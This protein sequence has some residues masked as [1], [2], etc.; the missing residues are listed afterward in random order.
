MAATPE[1]GEQA[2]ESAAHRH[3]L[4]CSFEA[5][6]NDN[7]HT[8]VEDLVARGYSRSLLLKQAAAIP[9]DAA[10]RREKLNKLAQRTFDIGTAKVVDKVHLI[11]LPYSHSTRLLNFRRVVRRHVSNF[12]LSDAAV[13]LGLDTW[14]T[15]V[16]YKA[17]PNMF[18]ENYGLNAPVDVGG[19]D[20]L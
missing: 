17:F 6:Y 4:N 11:V 14:P 7:M 10:K 2:L 5:D 16:A 1:A 8:M 20:C 19:Q 15:V 12:M 13:Q 3:L 9:Y 18:L